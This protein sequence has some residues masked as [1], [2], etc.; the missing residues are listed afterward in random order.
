MLYSDD[1]LGSVQKEMEEVNGD[2]NSTCGQRVE[3]ISQNSGKLVFYFTKVLKGKQV[4]APTVPSAVIRGS[5]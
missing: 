5:N 4:G 2:K 1:F 3:H